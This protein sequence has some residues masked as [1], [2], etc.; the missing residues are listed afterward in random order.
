MKNPV[1]P[2]KPLRSQNRPM[3]ALFLTPALGMFALLYLWPLGLSVVSSFCRWNGFEPMRFIG[4]NNYIELFGDQQFKSALW[5]SVR[6]ALCAAFIHVPFGVLV[7]LFLSRRFPLW[8]FV[9]SSFMLPNVISGSAMA[10]LFM[11]IFKP[12]AGVLNSVICIFAGPDFSINW[13]FDSRTAFVSLTQIWLWYAAVITLITLSQLLSIPPELYEA[14]KIDG[15]NEFQIDLWIN[16]PLLKNAIGT[17]VIIAVT[18]VFKMFDIIFMTTNGG[19]GTATINLAVMSVNA[20]ITLNKYGY[21]NAIGIFLLII[22]A[23]IMALTTRSF[24]MHDTMGE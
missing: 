18:S 15:A 6:W 10:L 21:A 13:L 12:D 2:K 8:R 24:R 23:S 20:I 16:V 22:G 1:S 9:R 17:G 19:P 11:F 7:A 14:A 5:N 3:I 4:L